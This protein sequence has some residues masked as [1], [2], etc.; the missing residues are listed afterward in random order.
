MTYLLIALV[1]LAIIASL[2]WIKPSPRQKQME[3]MRSRASG[4]G[5]TVQLTH[6]PDA[7]KGEGI[8]DYTLYLKPWPESGAPV[9]EQDWLLV[10]NSRRGDPTPWEGWRWLGRKALPGSVTGMKAAL[11]SL[12]ENVTGVTVNNLG[13]GAFWQERGELDDV[14]RIAT[15]LEKLQAVI[16]N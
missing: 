6:A 11:A 13:A 3:S 7:R 14:E 15:A 12:P 8:P 9:L 10:K 2:T 16:P 5:L 1:L 4:C